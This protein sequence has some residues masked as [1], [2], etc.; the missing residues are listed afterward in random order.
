MKRINGSDIYRRTL[1]LLVA[2][3]AA[4]LLAQPSALFAQE[5]SASLAYP[6]NSAPF[7]MTYGDWQAAYLQYMFSIPASVNPVNDLTGADCNV[8]QSSSPVFFL[9]S[10]VSGSVTRT[11]TI[12]AKALLITVAWAECSN[13][14]PPP[15]Y[16]ADPQ[17]M[18]TCA[19]VAT[20]GVGITTL[21]LTVDGQDLSGLLRSLRVQSPYY[22]FT[23]PPTDNLLGLEGVTSGWSVSDG[24]LVMLKPLPPGNHVIHFAGKFVSGPYG[25]DPFAV[26]YNLTVQ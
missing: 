14:E 3:S 25:P 16:G 22:F 12:P 20:N 7:G 21:R 9:N 4:I 26:T 19:A 10:I 5:A 17:D 15:S 11:C 23:M 6:A 2:M 18:R 8:A 13:I 24:Y 1:A